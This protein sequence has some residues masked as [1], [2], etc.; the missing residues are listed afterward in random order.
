LVQKP[1]FRKRIVR[2]IRKQLVKGIKKVIFGISKWNARKI[3]K[4]NLLVG[5]MRFS[6]PDVLTR[7]G[8]LPVQAF[9]SG[10]ATNW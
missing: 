6:K 3:P 5:Q 10:S 7:M 1:E 4:W 2:W 9:L 8:N